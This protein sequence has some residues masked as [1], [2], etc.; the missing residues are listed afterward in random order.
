MFFAAK[1]RKI[2]KK[3]LKP[4]QSFFLRFLR[5][6]AAINEFPLNKGQCLIERAPAASMIFPALTICSL[7]STETLIPMFPSLIAGS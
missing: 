7:E 6:I 1:M 3:I 5:L 2:R 4:R